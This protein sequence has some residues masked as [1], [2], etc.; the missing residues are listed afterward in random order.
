MSPSAVSAARAS[1]SA[2]H[3]YDASEYGRVQP[4]EP[5]A[6]LRRHPQWVLWQ[7]ETRA[8][9]ATKVPYGVHTGRRAD[10]R[11]PEARGTYAA[12]R[13]A[14]L[15]GG[16]RYAGLGFVFTPEDPFCGVDLDGALDAGG[17]VL[18]WAKE[19]LDRLSTYAEI[20][21]SGRGVKLFLR[22]SLARAAA[23]S[24]AGQGRVR[25]RRSGLGPGGTGSVELYDEGRFF[26]VTGKRLDGSP[27]AVARR[28]AELDL[29]YRELFPPP[30]PPPQR[31]RRVG[32]GTA[33]DETILRRA[34][35]AANGA[36]FA[37][38]WAGDA[39]AYGGD[40]SARDAALCACLA[41]Y[42]QDPAQVERL[43]NRSGCRR[44]KWDARPDYRQRTIRFA[45]GGAA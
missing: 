28:Q 33:D 24:E 18:Q 4:P 16:G 29:L 10:V 5:P 31:H 39:S 13:R 41:F 43:V 1:P 26:T 35:A 44:E 7:W 9:E 12:A 14:L 21:P 38:L 22:G 19:I 25:H 45:L 3:G 15:A 36:K 34:L 6:V 37:R 23:A 30:K 42:T 32:R 40:E 17:T 2:P 27:A 8:G 20:S 11:D